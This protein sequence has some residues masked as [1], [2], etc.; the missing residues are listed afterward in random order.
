MTYAPGF[1]FGE[2]E[3]CSTYGHH[4]HPTVVDRGENQHM[5]HPPQPH[6]YTVSVEADL[7]FILSV[8][9]DGTV[10]VRDGGYA[11]AKDAINNADVEDRLTS[12]PD[13]DYP[14][15]LLDKLADVREGELAVGDGY[16]WRAIRRGPIL[17]E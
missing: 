14:E 8:D 17:E 5:F 4:R 13:F 2:H 6:E 16:E 7:T 1:Y 9:V 11:L 12:K 3:G 15:A 10:R